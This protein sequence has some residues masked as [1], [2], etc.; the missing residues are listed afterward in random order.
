MRVTTLLA[1]RRRIHSVK[2]TQQITKAMEMVAGA[3]LRKIER[4]MRVMRSYEEKLIEILASVLP[5]LDGD[6]SP[7]M[8][9]RDNIKNLCLIVM[10]ADRGLCGAFN[11]NI[12]KYTEEFIA[13]RESDIFVVPCGRKMVRYFQKRP[14]T[15]IAE[16]EELYHS[17]ST[18]L[19]DILTQR[20][21]EA[22]EKEDV[23][24]VYVIYPHFVNIMTHPIEALKILPVSL[25]A[26]RREIE[27]LRRDERKKPVY[28][29][30]PNAGVV[31]YHLFSQYIAHTLFWCLLE[32]LTSEMGARMTA[33]QMATENAQSVIDALT[34]EYNQARQHSI[35]RELIDIVGTVEALK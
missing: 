25:E 8:M 30:E 6:E 7:L 10:G 19:T 26:I 2:N 18:T 28:E 29:L 3:R 14:Y 5:M 35:T 17:V 33:M 34:L 22:F 27:E 31:C 15:I 16:A 9:K 1:I 20:V 23:D 12:I 21:T 11:A 13:E 32:T 4:K 24:E